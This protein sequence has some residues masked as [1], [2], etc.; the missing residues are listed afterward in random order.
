MLDNEVRLGGVVEYVR[1]K[2]Q[3]TWVNCSLKL[4]GPGDFEYWVKVGGLNVG[5]RALQRVQDLKGNAVI[6]RGGMSSYAMPA[7]PP[8]YPNDRTI[9]ELSM[10]KSGYLLVRKSDA[11]EV[12]TACFVGRVVRS[13]ADSNGRLGLE[14]TIRYARPKT[15]DYGSHSARVRCPEGITEIEDDAEIFVVGRVITDRLG[16]LVVAQQLA[17]RP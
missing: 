14:V 13:K 11:L 3:K 5:D 4:R 12:N 15:K 17:Q 7:K 10:G 16:A 8:D 1:V 9:W 2:P 6:I